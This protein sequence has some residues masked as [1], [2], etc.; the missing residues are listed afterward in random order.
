MPSEKVGLFEGYVVY[1]D[2][3]YQ[4]SFSKLKTTISSV[5]QIEIC[6]LQESTTYKYYV[7]RALDNTKFGNESEIQQFT[8]L[9]QRM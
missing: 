6:D 9:G 1:Y 4:S 3:S 5:H 2:L 8:T 7:Q